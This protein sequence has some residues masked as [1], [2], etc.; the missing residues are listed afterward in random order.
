M[1][2]GIQIIERNPNIKYTTDKENDYRFIFLPLEA[3][4][5][6]ESKGSAI[7]SRKGWRPRPLAASLNV[8][9]SVVY[10]AVAKG[11]MKVWRI[12]KAIVIPE[13]EVQK[14]LDSKMEPTAA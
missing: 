1:R 9:N 12:G 2:L 14:W 6:E 8:A 3:S 13:E 5:A 10:E 7:E 4:M 11:E